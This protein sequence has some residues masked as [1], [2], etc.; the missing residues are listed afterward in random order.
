[1]EL[2]FDAKSLSEILGHAN[3]STTLSI[4]VHPTLQQKK[5]QI[6]LLATDRYLQS[7]L[8]DKPAKAF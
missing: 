7:N 2:G 3:V 6:E 8:Q 1:M 5:Q 4:Y